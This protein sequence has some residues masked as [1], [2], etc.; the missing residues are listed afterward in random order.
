MSHKE[1]AIL[2]YLLGKKNETVSRYDLL[3]KVW[4]YDESPT[5]RTVDKLY[6]QASSED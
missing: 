4:G 1:Y 2:Q 3:E 5:T 6:R